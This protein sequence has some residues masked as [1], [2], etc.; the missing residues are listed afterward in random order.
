MTLK[1]PAKIMGYFPDKK[2]SVVKNALI[3][4]QGIFKAKSVNLKEVK[5]ELPD[6]LG[7]RNTAPESNY[8]RLTRFF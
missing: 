7:N 2:E 8:R 5:D 3:V 1:I 6:I 4:A